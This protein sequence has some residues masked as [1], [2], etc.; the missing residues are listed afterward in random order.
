MTRAVTLTRGATAPS[1]R[2]YYVDGD[3]VAARTW[4]TR[5]PWHAPGEAEWS[6]LD[7]DA[8]SDAGVDLADFDDGGEAID[9]LAMPDRLATPDGFER[10]DREGEVAFIAPSAR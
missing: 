10:I 6:A 8:L 1:H 3:C 9:V 5:E 7:D 4:D 2:R